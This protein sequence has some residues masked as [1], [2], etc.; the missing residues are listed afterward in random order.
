LLNQTILD[1]AQILDH[2][3]CYPHIIEKEGFFKNKFGDFVLVLKHYSG[4]TLLSYVKKF[5]KCDMYID[6]KFLL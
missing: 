4:G 3:G 6:E 5:I 1:E 2:L